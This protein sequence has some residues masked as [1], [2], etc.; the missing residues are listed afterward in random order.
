MTKP[1]AILT[2]LVSASA[3]ATP[4]QQSPTVIMPKV[5]LLPAPLKPIQM[6]DIDQSV[7]LGR[8]GAM[9]DPWTDIQP[10]YEP[11]EDGGFRI[12]SSLR[13]FNRP[14]IQSQN[15]IGTGDA[16]IFRMTTSNGRGV[17]IQEKIFPLWPR[18]DVQAGSDDPPCLGTLRLGVP[19][20]DGRTR[21]LDGM[22]SVTTSFRPGYT[23][24]QITDPDGSWKAEV[25]VA[26]T[27]N[28]NGMICQVTFDREV[29]L[30]WQF[31]GVWWLSGEKNANQVQ[32]KGSQARITEAKLPNGLVLAGCDADCEGRVTA[33]SFG[34]LAEFTA[35][36]RKSYNIAAVWGVTSYDEDL[37]KKVMARLDTPISNAWPEIRNKLKQSWFDCYIKPALDP[38]RRFDEL[39]AK[40]ADALKQTRDR[41]DSRRAE[42]QIHTPD[43]H[44]NALI[45]W[46]R[47]R[48][49]YNRKGPGLWLS[50]HWQNY[51]H[52]STGWYG[53]EWSGDHQALDECYRLYGAAQLQNGCIGWVS[54][55]LIG[56]YQENDAPYWV[57][58][59]WRHYTWTGDKQFIMDLWPAVRKVVAWQ[60]RENDP[61]GDGLFRDH[62]EY[63][64]SDSGGR[65]PKAPTPSAMSW[66]MLDRASRMAEVVGDPAAAKDY[67]DLADVSRKKI[68][69][70]LWRDGRLG[71]IG[72]DGLWRGHPTIWDEHLAT[73][74]GLLTHDQ[75]RSAMR[76]LESHY[77][78]EPQPGVKLLATSDWYPVRWS[79]N[80]VHTGDTC[81][82]ALAGM[83]SGDLNVWWPYFKT[84]VMSAY[85]CNGPGIHMGISNYG[86]SG[87][88]LEDV[89]SAD[90]YL[91]TVIRGLFGVEP[92]LHEG[93]MDICP[94]FPSDWK[95]ASIH[96]PDISYDYRRDGNRAIF[97]IHTPK[98][99]VKHVR[100]NLTGPE[101]ITPAEKD[102]IVTVT[103]G[104]P[105]APPNPP[106]TKPIIME[107]DG[108]RVEHPVVSLTDAQRKRLVL[109]DLSRALNKTTEEFGDISFTFDF[110]DYSG[111]LYW[112]WR[113]P[114]YDMP[115]TPPLL[116]VSNGVRFLVAERKSSE[117]AEPPKNILA[118]SSWK[119]YPVP[120]GAVIS[121]GKRCKSLW[122]LLRCYVHPMSNYI[123][124]GEIIL[125][126][127][128]GRTAM[129]S[130]I[131]PFN[132][133]TMYQPFSLRGIEVPFGK[134]RPATLGFTPL[135]LV[136]SHATAL[137]VPCDPAQMLESVEFRAVCSEGVLGI[138][139]LTAECAL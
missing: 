24:Y 55:T 12:S 136:R 43:V 34:Q 133:D 85:K 132:L 122:T 94:A 52:I 113:N 68:F 42:F 86:A 128:G 59:V 72:A 105:I 139:G 137:E 135:D 62:Y 1:I 82:A 20:S 98:P 37:A 47:A 14:I 88:D 78:F 17:Y 109:F 32:I 8:T 26:P 83:K 111:P 28:S 50:E 93:R 69:A 5:T 73:N 25:I 121:V 75:S 48:T 97:K 118:L 22:K 127:A 40:P 123:P 16:P 63:W 77:G 19:A 114:R 11:I 125:H 99:L 66:A 51:C 58:Q 41:W 76:W 49:E 44:L 60:R 31:G 4:S 90:P 112:W 124:N 57:D 89:D 129:I 84:A 7:L 21:W 95:T 15:R 27:P 70:E 64:N 74:A 67:R 65:G 101:A 120:G 138:A 79:N 45:N 116:E 110:Q 6:P 3:F 81:L 104:T 100:A 13:Q 38:E 71:A 134:I 39:M 108:K 2:I 56:N 23:E 131:P 91:H 107:R 119:P 80:W 117:G 53:K 36:P 92:A 87:G 61:D 30:V 10:A 115:P 103:L 9:A 126:Y 33:A 18:P 46:E 54:P 102:S 29:P 96:S 106:K 35:K 130:L